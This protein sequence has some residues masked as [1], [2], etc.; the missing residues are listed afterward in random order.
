MA[1]ADKQVWNTGTQDTTSTWDRSG[2]AG[3]FLAQFEKSDPNHI[4]P[5]ISRI[6]ALMRFAGDRIAP[7]LATIKANL[8]VA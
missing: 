3:G 1:G 5:L 4:E 8:N 6:E 2:D 7:D